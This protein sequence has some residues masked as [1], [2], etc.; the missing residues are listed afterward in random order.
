[1]KLYKKSMFGYDNSLTI[2]L[3]LA[4]LVALILIILALKPTLFANFN[5]LF[6]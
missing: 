1:M 2:I 3:S 5:R 4:L 6:D